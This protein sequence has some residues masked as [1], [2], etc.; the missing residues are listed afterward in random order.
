MKKT[1]LALLATTTIGMGMSH[2]Q[3][4]VKRYNATYST[5][6]A[7][8]PL[9]NA[10]DVGFA[11]D[12]DDTV[13]DAI[14]LPFTFKYQNTPVS[15]VRIETYGSLFLND[16]MH[17]DVDM[18]HITGVYMDYVS[19]GR[20]KVF[21]TTTGTAGNRI[22]K[23]EYRNVGRYNDDNGTDTLNFQIWL[24]ESDNAIE[25][26]GGYSNV[27]D[28]MFAKD[29]NDVLVGEKELIFC[30]LVSNPGDSIATTGGNAFLHAAQYLNNTFYN[31]AV[32]LSDLQTPNPLIIEDLLYGAFPA[33]GSVIRF[34]PVNPNS[35][36]KVDFDMASVYPNPSKDGKYSL[37]LKEAP[38]A[39]ATLTIY[40]MTGK[41]VLNQSLNQASTAIDLTAYANGN[42]FGKISNGGRTGSF[43]LIKE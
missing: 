43:K 25:Y 28:T 13:S 42:Y 1:L 37:T 15:T 16:L 14:N 18:G 29:A 17:E 2:A 3:T 32:L 9:T 4:P 39:G 26:R 21:Y 38:Q 33:N 36:S 20:G 5:G 19:A 34:V 35:I 8:A 41:A 22:F 6:A 23:V 11:V 12:W 24:Y 31:N 40:D 30:G 7:Y 10:T 27:S